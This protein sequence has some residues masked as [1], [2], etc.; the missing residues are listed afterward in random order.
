MWFLA[1]LGAGCGPSAPNRRTRS[2]PAGPSSTEPVV[3]G[4]QA[5][6]VA[7]PVSAAEL[8]AVF[9]ALDGLSELPRQVAAGALNLQPAPCVPCQDDGS[10]LARC[11]LALPPGCENVPGLVN[12]A[13]RLAAAGASPTAV[14]AVLNY[15][16]PWV[17]AP[18]LD[19]TAWPDAAAPVWVELWVDPAFGPW[20]EAADRG[21]ELVDAGSQ[22]PELGPVSVRVGLRSQRFGGDEPAPP[23]ATEAARA[24]AAADLQGQGLP[25]LLAL[26]HAAPQGVP[27]NQALEQAAQDTL[28]LDRVRWQS[29]RLG[30]AV[31]ARLAQDQAVAQEIGFRSSPSWRIDGYRLG[32]HRSTAALREV[33]ENERIDRL[34][35][36]PPALLAPWE[37][38]AAPPGPPLRPDPAPIP[39]PNPP[40]NPAAKP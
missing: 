27:G 24:V 37:P 31:A 10:S 4:G 35:A 36:V 8:S 21:L 38:A 18:A 13:I 7:N 23:G 12:R 2:E 39:V 25:Y 14:G 5:R 30:P 32:G 1:L 9:P 26:A 11:A 17:P 34:P 19:S 28:G 33:V 20:R 29:E 6:P 15:N 22:D 16:D 3:V 40:P